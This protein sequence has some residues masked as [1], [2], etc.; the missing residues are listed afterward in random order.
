MPSNTAN[1][2]SR[3]A[4]GSGI[5]RRDSRAGGWP[6]VAVI[7]RWSISC[8]Q[9]DPDPREALDRPVA[10]RLPQRMLA[11]PGL[12]EE[13]NQGRRR[14]A[15]D[16]EPPD[17]E[18]LELPRGESALRGDPARSEEGAEPPEARQDD[19]AHVPTDLELLDRVLHRVG[20][21]VTGRRIIVRRLV[22]NLDDA[23][24]TTEQGDQDDDR[25]EDRESEEQTERR[26]GRDG[27]TGRA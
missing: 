12:L 13:G 25:R 18:V 3:P 21:G 23:C 4:A 19:G 7:P 24:A 10:V 20:C 16:V 8:L 11:V 5:R 14:L 26:P 22:V 17:R 27:P 6:V 15:R 1:A 2:R 9:C